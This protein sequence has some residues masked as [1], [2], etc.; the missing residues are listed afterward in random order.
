MYLGIIWMWEKHC[1]ICT[2]G[3]L[4]TFSLKIF[5]FYSSLFSIRF[6]SPKI[7]SK[8]I[9]SGKIIS[10]ITVLQNHPLFIDKNNHNVV[11]PVLLFCL[12]FCW[13]VFLWASKN[14]LSFYGDHRSPSHRRASARHSIPWRPVTVG[15]WTIFGRPENKNNSW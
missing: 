15:T 10:F 2:T 12:Q 4:S 3:K 6:Y 5:L 1:M 8:Q 9:I 11:L 13:V 14:C 7:V